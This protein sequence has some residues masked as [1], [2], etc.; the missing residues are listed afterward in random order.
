MTQNLVTI[1]YQE[2][3]PPPHFAPIP[4]PR[5]WRWIPGIFLRRK[6][7]QREHVAR[8]FHHRRLV[9]WE[10]AG[11]V[12]TF[13]MVIPRALITPTGSDGEYTITCLSANTHEFFPSERDTP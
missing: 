6:R 5:L 9:E 12:A 8:A 1:E 10:D 11:R 3:V 4:E 2:E 13:R 7:E